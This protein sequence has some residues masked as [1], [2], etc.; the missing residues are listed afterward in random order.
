NNSTRPV[1]LYLFNNTSG[2]LTSDNEDSNM[3]ERLWC[4]LKDG[5]KGFATFHVDI[6]LDECVCDLQAAIKT[7]KSNDLGNIDAD[8]LI[9]WKV[10]IPI[11]KDAVYDRDYKQSV[12]TF[13]L[14]SRNKMEGSDEIR[15]YIEEAL[16]KKIQVVVELPKQ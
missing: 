11:V 9:L 3:S 13:K 2:A 10:E 1:S 4:L 8:R 7:T 5:K 16:P 15:I 12:D 14:D 6:S